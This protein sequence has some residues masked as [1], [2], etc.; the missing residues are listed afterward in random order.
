[1]FG[2]LLYILIGIAFTYCVEKYLADREL[3]LEAYPQGFMVVW[4]TVFWPAAAALIAYDIY[5]Q[6]SIEDG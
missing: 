2:I 5:E 3:D 4:Q 1:M 6:H